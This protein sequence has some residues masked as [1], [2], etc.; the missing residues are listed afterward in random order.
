MMDLDVL[1]EIEEELSE[2]DGMKHYVRIR[3]LLAGGPVVAL[4]G[5]KYIPRI[6]GP[7]V[8]D[9]PTC[10]KCHEL[11]EMLKDFHGDDD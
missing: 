3:A 8:F 9:L 2:F 5:K 10:E 1:P 6:I 7:E 4:C 11:M